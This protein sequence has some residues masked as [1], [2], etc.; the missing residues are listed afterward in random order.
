LKN[1]GLAVTLLGKFGNNVMVDPSFWNGKRVFLT[2]HTGFKGGWLVLWLHRMGA[3]VVGYSLPPETKPNLF[4]TVD[5]ASYCET[6]TFG[7]IRDVP[8]LSKAL[9][10]SNPDVVMHLAAQAIVKTGFDDPVQTFETNVMGTIN[11]MEAVRALPEHVVCLI[12]TSDKCYDN[13]NDGVPLREQDPLGGHDPYSASKGACEVAV[14]S[15]QHSYFNDLSMPVLASGRAGNVIGGGD[16]S[17]N[18]LL[19]DA[20]RAFSKGEV[21]TVRNPLATRPWQHV[22]EPLSGYLTLIQKLAAD[23]KLPKA[24]NFGPVPAVD[25]SVEKVAELAAGAWGSSARVEVS[26]NRQNWEEAHALL[27]DSTAAVRFLHWRPRLDVP[28]AVDMT[29]KWYA[30]FYETSGAGMADY[31]LAQIDDYCAKL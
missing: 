24:W 16:W 21:L 30:R 10:D 4:D 28:E 3:K 15:W 18:R 11:V 14:T 13:P 12:V 29:M 8:A 31:T 7:D 9:T 19:A 27:L 6:S 22:L 23:R 25:T 26:Q 17:A 20:A 2:G 5:V 1:F